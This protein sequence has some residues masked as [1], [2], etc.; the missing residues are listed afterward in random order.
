MPEPNEA[1]SVTENVEVS[2]KQTRATTK[3]RPNSCRHFRFHAAIVA[4]VNVRSKL[5]LNPLQR[6]AYCICFFI[7]VN[8]NITLEIARSAVRLLRVRGAVLFAPNCYDLRDHRI[9]I[10]EICEPK[11][12]KFGRKIEYWAAIQTM[13]VCLEEDGCFEN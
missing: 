10:I 9:Q 1:A 7:Y 5:T 11:V 2:P 12:A 4:Q 8:R 6:N 3:Q 13:V